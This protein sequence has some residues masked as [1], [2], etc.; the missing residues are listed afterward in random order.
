M[1]YN[2]WMK[3]WLELYVKP[4]TKTRTLAKYK[5]QTEIHILPLLGGYELC[6]LTA[7]VLQR[8]TVNLSEK[9][10]S[11]NTVNGIISLLKTSLKRA[12]QTGAVDK[13]FSHAVVRPKGKEKQV[14]CFTKDE[15]RRIEQYIF[16]KKKNKLFGV[17]L[18]L[19][20]GLRIGELLALTWNDVD[21]GKGVITVSK[22]C[23]DRWDKGKY[24]KIID[25]PKTDCST[26]VIPI[27]KQLLPHIKAVKKQSKSDYVVDGKGEY[28][29]GVRS[30]QN[31]LQ[32]LAI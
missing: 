5:R 6:D 25:T 15:Q 30:Y 21:L 23:G 8:F 11:A 7:I 28:G 9:G 27:P 2:N 19:Y 12:V 1:N 26:R 20:T 13:E 31:T 16:K 4:A 3:D 10:L 24:V 22:T 14:D 32:V 29:I 17:V 18:C